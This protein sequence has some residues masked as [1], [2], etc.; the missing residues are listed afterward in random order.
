[1]YIERLAP[2]DPGSSGNA[3]FYHQ[4]FVSQCL[5]R[6]HASCSSEQHVAKWREAEGDSGCGIEGKSRSTNACVL[7]ELTHYLMPS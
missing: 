7:L 4:I 3:V 5:T 6:F 1:M 2:I